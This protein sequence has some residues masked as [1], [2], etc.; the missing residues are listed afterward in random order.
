MFPPKN[1]IKI[2]DYDYVSISCASRVIPHSILWE[3]IYSGEIVT[4]KENNSVYLEM[5]SLKNIFGQ[6][7]VDSIFDKKNKNKDVSL[8]KSKDARKGGGF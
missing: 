3:G 1:T 5:Q 6:D 2:G 7:L 8:P 4:T